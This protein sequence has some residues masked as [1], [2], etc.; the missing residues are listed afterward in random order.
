[1][2]LSLALSRPDL[3]IYITKAAPEPGSDWRNSAGPGRAISLG[4]V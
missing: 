2:R 3:Y 4:G 1:M